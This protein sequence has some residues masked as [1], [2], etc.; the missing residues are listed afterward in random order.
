MEDRHAKTIYTPEQVQQI[1]DAARENIKGCHSCSINNFKPCKNALVLLQSLADGRIQIK[2]LQAQAP[3]CPYGRTTGWYC[4]IPCH[5]HRGESGMC[6]FPEPPAR[7]L[8][9]RVTGF[10]RFDKA[11][12]DS[13]RPA[14]G[15]TEIDPLGHGHWVPEEAR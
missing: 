5:Y 3:L 10:T 6:N 11:N 13:S 8:Y 15:Q 4:H 9:E 7:Y 12:S 14:G 2:D 1:I